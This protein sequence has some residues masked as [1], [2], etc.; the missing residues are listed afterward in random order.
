[1]GLGL[2]EMAL[3]CAAVQVDLIRIAE[4]LPGSEKVFQMSIFLLFY[5]GHAGSDRVAM[6]FETAVS[7]LLDGLRINGSPS[8][9]DAAPRF[10]AVENVFTASATSTSS[11]AQPMPGGGKDRDTVR[12]NAAGAKR[13]SAYIHIYVYQCVAHRGRSGAGS[14]CDRLT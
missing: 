4:L 14:V 1:M 10:P 12:L 11:I 2:V 8:D 13:A 5:S 9:F 7:H 3:T 6:G